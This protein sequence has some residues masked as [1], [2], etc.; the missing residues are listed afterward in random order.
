ML[1]FPVLQLYFFTRYFHFSHKGR[2]FVTSFI[3]FC[4]LYSTFSS[5]AASTISK[6]SLVTRL[7]SS[8]IPGTRILY[9]SRLKPPT[10]SQLTPDIE[11]SCWKEDSR[12]LP[13]SSKKLLVE[14]K[15]FHLSL[16]SSWL[17]QM[18]FSLKSFS[19]ASS[20]SS[21][22]L[23]IC[24]CKS[25]GKNSCNYYL[26]VI[27]D[28]FFLSLSLLD[29]FSY[30]FPSIAKKQQSSKSK[31]CKTNTVNLKH[32]LF[33]HCILDLGLAIHYCV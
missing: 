2:Q 26:R 8:S 22:S 12:Y 27:F 30:S 15:I 17:N 6:I 28:F 4:C 13:N 21:F 5:S 18:I 16:S 19:M 20:K 23:D 7:T 14:I 33:Y 29:N 11:D 9:S 25:L 31:Y 3:T 32:C 10:Y 24:K 1:Q